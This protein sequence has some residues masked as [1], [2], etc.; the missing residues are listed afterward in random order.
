MLV[1]GAR[2]REGARGARDDDSNA[3]RAGR[4]IRTGRAR[5]ATNDRLTTRRAGMI[6]LT[7]GTNKKEGF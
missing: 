3:T 7:T 1:K 4:A 5:D 2:A 6:D